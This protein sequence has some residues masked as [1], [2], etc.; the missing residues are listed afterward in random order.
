MN[1][2]KLA[3][4]GAGLIGQ[5]HLEIAHQIAECELVAICDTNPAGVHIAQ[6]YDVPFYK[7]IIACLQK[8][9]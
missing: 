4:I 1:A 2:V 5:R 9:R 7:T 3:V 6:Q 8:S